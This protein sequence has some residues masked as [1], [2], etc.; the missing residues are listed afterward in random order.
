MQ[1]VAAEPQT[2]AA[3]ALG[4]FLA[5]ATILA[6]LPQ[7]ILLLNKRSSCGISVLT[8]ALALTYG[9][10]NVCST[11]LVKW[12]VLLSV[13]NLSGTRT[14]STYTPLRSAFESLLRIVCRQS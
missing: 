14:S 7:V 5:V 3:V 9:Y 8:P 6:V 13:H 4:V 10:L 12:R 1:C 2:P 11:V